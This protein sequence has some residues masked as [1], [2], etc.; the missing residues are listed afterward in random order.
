MS[1]SQTLQGVT[2]KKAALAA[3]RPLSASA[4]ARLKMNLILLR[5]GYPPAI[6]RHE[7]RLAYYAALDQA[8]AG[9]T[10]PFTLMM[11]EAVER[12]LDIFLAA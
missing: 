5:E 8:H 9:E 6:V 11:A 3:R 12:S 7:A 10:K 2:A 1:L 4:V